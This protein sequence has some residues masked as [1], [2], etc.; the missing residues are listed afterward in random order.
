MSWTVSSENDSRW[1][2]EGELDE[3]AS[4]IE[5]LY[6]IKEIHEWINHCKK[7]FG[8]IPDDL[9]SSHW[10]YRKLIKFYH[11]NI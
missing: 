10:D 3:P 2:K 6:R 7:N 5:R 1:N 9:K 4:M 8:Q 11:W